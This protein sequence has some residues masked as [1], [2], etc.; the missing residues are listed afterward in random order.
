GPAGLLP[1]P[2]SSYPNGQVITLDLG[3][4]N[5]ISDMNNNAFLDFYCE[6]DTGVDFMQLTVV[7]CCCSINKTVECG[8]GW[9][10][11]VPSAM[12]AYSGAP[13]PATILSTVTNGI[14]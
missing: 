14:C 11:D 7:S 10:F 1:N 4:L 2:W 12:D 9:T 13:V 3:A 6:D 8:S 5:L